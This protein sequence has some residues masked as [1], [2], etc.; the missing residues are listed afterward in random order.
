MIKEELLKE[1]EKLNKSDMIEL[2]ILM[3]KKCEELKKENSN[4][5][6]LKYNALHREKILENQR[7]YRRRK[8]EEIAAEMKKKE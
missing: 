2:A 3:N 8:K 4:Y 1:I 5:R 6:I 7:D